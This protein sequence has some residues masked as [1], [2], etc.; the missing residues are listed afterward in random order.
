MTIQEL[1][2]KMEQQK[3]R[4]AWQKGVIEYAW[5]LIDNIEM[6]LAPEEQELPNTKLLEKMMLNG[7][8]NWNEYS[9]GGYSLIYDMDIAAK[10]CNLTELKKTENGRKKPN[11]REEWLDTQACVSNHSSR[12][13]G[14]FLPFS[15]FLSSVRLH[16]FA[17]ISIS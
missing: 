16:N 17:A 9:W 8:S 13:L 4:S 10:L 14:F 7:A 2:N 15:V 12:A 5:D 11:A 1:R 6:A 3:A